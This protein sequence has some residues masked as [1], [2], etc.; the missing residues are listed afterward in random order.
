MTNKKDK[1]VIVSFSCNG[2]EQYNKGTLRLIDSCKACGYDGDYLFQQ[3]DGNVTEHS[4]V[5]ITQGSYPHSKLFN[6]A[7]HSEVPYMFKLGMIQLAREAGYEKIVWVDSSVCLAKPPTELL[8]KAKEIG[9]VSFDCLGHPLW[10]WITDAA[11]EKLQITEEE[12]KDMPQI[13]AGCLVWDFSNPVAVEV[14]EEWLKHAQDGVSFLNGTSNREGFKD[15]R[16][17]QAVLSGILNKRKIKSLPY[18]HMVQ[19]IHANNLEYGDY[20]TFVVKGIQ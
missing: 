4:G 7:T 8:E 20:F 2:R 10:K 15:H 9:V 3:A 12:L 1:P 14:F 13:M 16:H 17:D 6:C 19:E 5:P 11:L 18:N